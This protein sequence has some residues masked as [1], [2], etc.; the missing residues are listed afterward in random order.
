ML[1]WSMVI[2]YSIVNE[3]IELWLKTG[4]ISIE[5]IERSSFEQQIEI[6]QSNLKLL[7]IKSFE[8]NLNV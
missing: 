6:H 3:F 1:W 5:I 2:K 7:S 4:W 8:L